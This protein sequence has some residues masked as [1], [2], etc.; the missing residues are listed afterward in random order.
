MVKE[1]SK[2]VLSSARGGHGRIK[3]REHNHETHKWSGQQD[4]DWS[5]RSLPK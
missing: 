4:Q 2:A 5:D 3:S 1:A